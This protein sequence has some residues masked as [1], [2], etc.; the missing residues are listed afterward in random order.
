MSFA[1]PERRNIPASSKR[2]R[3]R[4]TDTSVSPYLERAFVA[5]TLTGQIFLTGTQPK[6]DDEGAITPSASD[7]NSRYNRY[8]MKY[9]NSRCGRKDTQ[10]GNTLHHYN[11]YLQ[12]HDSN[13]RYRTHKYSDRSHLYRLKWVHSRRYNFHNDRDLRLYPYKYHCSSS[14]QKDST[15][16]LHRSNQIGSIPNR[17]SRRYTHKFH[18]C[19]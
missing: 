7:R 3:S 4:M 15:F 11:M 14:D 18:L 9:S 8:I 5:L 6:P 17:R 13:H 1:S 19:K 10:K 12:Q 2:I 16:R